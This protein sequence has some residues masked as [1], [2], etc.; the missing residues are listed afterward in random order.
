[1][2][3]KFEN[4]SENLISPATKAF[5]ITPHDTNEFTNIPRVVHCNSDGDV[6]GI[7][8]DDTV[9]QTFTVKAGQ[10]LPYRFKVITTATTVTSLVGLY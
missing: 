6:V 1:M 10:Q 3:D 8:K 9:A 4:F 7:L 5:A 2:A